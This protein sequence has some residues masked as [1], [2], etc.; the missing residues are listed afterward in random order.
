MRLPNSPITSGNRSDMT[1][2]VGQI[3]RKM[4]LCVSVIVLKQGYPKYADNSFVKQAP[5]LPFAIGIDQFPPLNSGVGLRGLVNHRSDLLFYF[6]CDFCQVGRIRQGRQHLTWQCC[7]Y[8][9]LAVLGINRHA[10]GK[11]NVHSHILG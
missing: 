5:M 7:G 4:K 1:S 10:A 3:E 11:G 8:L 6:L 9:S 2:K